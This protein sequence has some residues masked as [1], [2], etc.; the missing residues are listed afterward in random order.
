MR[1]CWKLEEQKF[2]KKD[3]ALLKEELF[4]RFVINFKE[5][6][7]KVIILEKLFTLYNEFR[8]YFSNVTSNRFLLNVFFMCQKIIVLNSSRFTTFL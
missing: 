4:L 7:Y 6:Y 1:I 8:A 2:D 3:E 5:F